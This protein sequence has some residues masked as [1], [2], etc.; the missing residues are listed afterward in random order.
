[1][2][3]GVTVGCSWEA[4]NERTLVILKISHS[5]P[6]EGRFSL[7]LNLDLVLLHGTHS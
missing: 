7:R 4:V 3:A 2:G 6:C 1:M 5:Q